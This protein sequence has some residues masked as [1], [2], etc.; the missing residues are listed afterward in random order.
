MRL[1]PATATAGAGSIVPAAGSRE[2][3][4][5]AAAGEQRALAAA[6]PG[7]TA[8]FNELVRLYQGSA[9]R[10]A[11]RVLGDR[12][13]AADA[14]QEAFF[15]AFKNLHRFH[16][17]SFR[18]WLLRI[19]TNACYDY[20]RARR[21]RPA[22]SLDALVSGGDAPEAGWARARD[23][24]PEEFAERRELGRVIEKGIGL[25]P[26]EQRLTLILSDVEGCSYPE[27]AQITA[28]NIGT[29]KSRLSRARALLREF[30]LSQPSY[31]RAR[32]WPRAAA[33]E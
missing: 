9:Y 7:D 24:S 12:E 27:I 8:A 2:Y 6:A 5:Q 4:R 29:V 21:R 13:A 19:V 32:A 28:T 26:L 20:L 14:T 25:L 17:P 1:V 33:A 30:L 15:S 3:P 16:G 23:E 18:A 31:S 22:Q 11:F 10:T